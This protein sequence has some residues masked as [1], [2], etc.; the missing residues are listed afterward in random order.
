M[1]STIEIATKSLTTAAECREDTKLMMQPYANWEEFLTPA[2]MS[3]A[4]LAEL[5]FISSKQDFSIRKGGPEKGFKH[6][7]YPDSFRACLMQVCNTGW[8][9]FNDAHKSMDQIR[10]YTSSVPKYIKI[11]VRILL[12]DDDQLVETM[13]PDQ[14]DSI[15]RISDE[16]LLLATGTERKFSDVIDLIS[17]LLE[18]CTSAKQVYGSELEAVRRKIEESKIRKQ[19]AEE[20]NKQAEEA[21]KNLSKELKEAQ[22]SY[23]TAMDSIP[24]GWEMIGMNFVEGLSNSV[25]GLLS[26]VTSIVCS[27]ASIVTSISSAISPGS[28]GSPGSVPQPQENKDQISKNNIYSKSTQIQACVEILAKC[29]DGD[30]INL[31]ELIDEKTKQPKTNWIQAELQKIQESINKEKDSQPKTEALALCTK[32][33]KICTEIASIPPEGQSDDAKTKE[34]VTLLSSLRKEVLAFDTKSKSATNASAFPPKPPQLSQ[35]QEQS[36]DSGKKS[37]GQMAADNARYRIE[38][39]RAQ[40]DKVRDL[41]EKKSELMA[42]KKKELTEILVTLQNCKVTEIDFNATIKILSEGL[43]AMG[44]V[45]EQWQKMVGFFQ[46]VSNLIKTCLKTSLDDFVRTSEKTTN[47][48]LKYSSRMF[49]KDMI[50]NQAFQASNVSS[51]VNMISGTYTEVSNKYLMDSVSKLSTLMSMDVTKPEFQTK[52]LEMQNSCKDAEE[53]IRSL[54]KRNKETFERKTKERLEKIENGLKAVLPAESEEKIREIQEVV[55][56]ASKEEQDEDQYA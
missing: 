44:E 7:Q 43:R 8:R 39:S 5:I 27:P 34:I 40:L 35:S 6:V 32:A 51:L 33:T 36:S 48:A 1:A 24:S 30:K 26:G 17:E 56:S 53:G 52:R 9:A 18:T 20:A 41:Y 45:Q 54:V 25:N 16:C 42:E 23:K 22:E 14:L 11:A 15:S 31:S 12:Q 47:K 21:I 50:Y 2:P 4:I 46:M 10:L 38:Q 13:L 37:A 3:I 55:Q 28:S 49:M 29:F 19:A